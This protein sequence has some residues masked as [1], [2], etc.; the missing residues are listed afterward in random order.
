MLHYGKSS[1]G[2]ASYTSSSRNLQAQ[3]V[4]L[5]HVCT[6]LCEES[7]TMWYRLQYYGT[8][9]V[10]CGVYGGDVRDMR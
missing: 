9:S 2:T 8:G 1:T 5:F 6:Q 4:A 7:S 3:Q 10:L